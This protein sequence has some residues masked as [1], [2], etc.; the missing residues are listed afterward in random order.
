[1]FYKNYLLIKYINKMTLSSKKITNSIYDS[2]GN[3][4]GFYDTSNLE[5]SNA[6]YSNKNNKIINNT[7]N[8]N[9]IQ[10]KYIKNS[11]ER[12]T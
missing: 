8:T 7:Y 9:I 11:N 1:M 3:V 2:C 4:K 12:K 6:Y 10:N 5:Y